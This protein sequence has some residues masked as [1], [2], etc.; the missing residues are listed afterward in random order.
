MKKLLTALLL[1]GIAVGICFYEYTIVVDCFDDSKI[2][3]EE[4]SES[5]RK[6][7]FS[8]AQKKA[9]GLEVLWNETENRLSHLTNSDSLEE[10]G[11]SLSR[12][13]YLAREESDEFL[14]EVRVVRV[15]FEHLMD[16]NKYNMF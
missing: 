1:L 6:E 4:M 12:L 14:A 2:Y 13:P 8:E 16:R 10:I 15:K 11:E 3:F 7:N 9:Q 5:F